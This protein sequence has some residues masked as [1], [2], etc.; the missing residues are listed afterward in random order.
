MTTSCGGG[1]SQKLL[2]LSNPPFFFL[3][4]FPLR[5]EFSGHCG[6]SERRTV[7]SSVKLR[8]YKTLGLDAA[9]P[10]HERI[11]TLMSTSPRRRPRP[12]CLSVNC[13]SILLCSVIG[14]EKRSVGGAKGN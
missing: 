2:I 1:A 4:Q 8:V 5:D 13:V 9:L 11:T 10:R 6:T 14:L 7:L 3:L 12:V